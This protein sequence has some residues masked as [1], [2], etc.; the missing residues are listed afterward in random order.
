ME[1]RLQ[2]SAD[3]RGGPELWPVSRHSGAV[4]RGMKSKRRYLGSLS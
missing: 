3:R 4:G 1:S 2:P